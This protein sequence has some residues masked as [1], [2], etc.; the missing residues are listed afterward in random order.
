VTNG[1]TAVVP[2]ATASSAALEILAGGVAR[3][4]DMSHK[5][6][7]QANPPGHNKATFKVHLAKAL[8]I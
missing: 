5:V 2:P 6:G 1:G 4:H 8:A 7:R 3:H